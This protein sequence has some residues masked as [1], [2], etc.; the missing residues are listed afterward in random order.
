MEISKFPLLR[1]V[2][3]ETQSLLAINRELLP[4]EFTH[5]AT[6]AI[7]SGIRTAFDCHTNSTTAA[8][9]FVQLMEGGSK[10]GYENEV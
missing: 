6:A 5:D 3:W 10:F 4:L 8:M 7:G 2:K 1:P 9:C